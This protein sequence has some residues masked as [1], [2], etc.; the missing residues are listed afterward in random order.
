[1]SPFLNTLTIVAVVLASFAQ[2]AVNIPLGAC[3]GFAVNAGTAV[4]FAG[5][6]TTIATGNMGVSP[7]TSIG[8]NVLLGTGSFERQST[9]S[10]ACAAD[11]DVAYLAAS[12]AVPTV[13]L[14]LSSGKNLPTADLSGLTLVPGVYSSVGS[15]IV[16]ATTVTLDGQGDPNAQFIF[17]AATSLVTSTATSF[18]LVN[19]ASAANV[20]WVVGTGVTLGNSASFVGTIMAGTAVTFNTNAVLVGRALAHTAVTFAGLGTV[21]LPLAT[22]LPTVPGILSASPLSVSA[23]NHGNL[24]SN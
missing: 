1:M 22:A 7:G 16:S 6:V 23:E 18:I 11:L 17:Q 20:Y 19:G 8:G 2:G 21:T 15:I 5:T 13:Y 3:A 9:L 12:Q 14:G 10:I 4:T 24:R